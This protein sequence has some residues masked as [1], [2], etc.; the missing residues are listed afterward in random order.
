[1]GNASLLD[2][3]NMPP[4]ERHPKIFA[5]FDGLREGET[6]ELVNDHDPKPLYYQ[7]MHERS[8]QF[9]WKYE[10]EGPEVWRVSIGKVQGINAEA[11]QNAPKLVTPVVVQGKP[12]W[13]QSLRKDAEITLDVRSIIESGL[14]PFQDIMKTVKELRAGQHLRLVNSFEPVPLYAILGNNGFEHFAECR[15]GVW[16][17]YF[18]KQA[19]EKESFPGGPGPQP[20]TGELFDK[21]VKR[22]PRVELDVRGLPPPEPMIKITEAL[23]SIPLNGLLFVHHYREPVLLYD[24]LKERGYEAFTR[25][26]GE[27][28]YKVL[29]WK[30]E[31]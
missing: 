11:I 30:K 25:K 13:V 5:A 12:A 9:K 28:D 3:R 21:M 31:G 18:K 10:E 27:E 15:E 26:M 1:M 29:V 19:G 23:S 4:R 2:V 20:V 17:I 14:E 6:F 8:D 22:T 16:S 7:F 24:K